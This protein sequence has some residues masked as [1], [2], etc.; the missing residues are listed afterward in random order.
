M[1]R[2][3]LVPL[4]Q[5][6]TAAC[7]VRVGLLR[8]RSDELGGYD[9]RF[10]RDVM[11]AAVENRFGNELHTQSEIEWLSDG[12]SGYTADETRR[13]ARAGGL[14]PLITPV[15]SPQSNRAYVLRQ[16]LGADLGL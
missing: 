6:R 10:V 12:G 4:R 16:A 14:K 15:C 11:L 1:F 9:S 7:D 3:L 5:R 8:S 2:W 13:F